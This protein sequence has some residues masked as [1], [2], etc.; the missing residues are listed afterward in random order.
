MRDPPPVHVATPT[1]SAARHRA[2]RGPAKAADLVL[3]SGGSAAAAF[4]FMTDAATIFSLLN[5][6]DEEARVRFRFLEA[7]EY[8]TPPH[9]GSRSASTAS[10]HPAA[11]SSIREVWAFPG[12]DRRR[13]DVHARR[14][15][16]RANS[17]TH[18]S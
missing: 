1:T 17:G 15:S 3:N 14:R 4:V 5:I 12:G 10:C 13:P 2:R 11:E 8:G 16:M 6:S 7:L 9:G 18:S